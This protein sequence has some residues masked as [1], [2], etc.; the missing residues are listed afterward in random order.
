MPLRTLHF[1]IDKHLSHLSPIIPPSPLPHLPRPISHFLGYRPHGSP[2][3]KQPLGNVLVSA[4]AFLGA[5]LGLVAVA[6]LFEADWISGRGAPIIVGSFG[7]AAVLE[8]NG[9]FILSFFLSFS[10]LFLS[11]LQFLSFSFGLSDEVMICV[12]VGC[13]AASS[14]ARREGQ[15]KH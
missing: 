15:S 4:W 10:L 5:F 3:T 11:T 14:D 6:G 2:T 13:A 8:F 9:M 7:A 12:E 1:S